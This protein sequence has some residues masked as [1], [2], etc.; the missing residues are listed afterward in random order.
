MLKANKFFALILCLVLAVSCHIFAAEDYVT[1]KG[2]FKDEY[3]DAV[4][5]FMGMG[6]WSEDMAAKSPDEFISRASFADMLFK[7]TAVSDADFSGSSYFWDVTEETVGYSAINRLAEAGIVSGND[8]GSFAP[9]DNLTLY[10]AA[11]LIVC[12]LGYSVKAEFDGGYSAGYL[13]VA[14]RLGI[15]KGLYGSGEEITKENAVIMLY[16]ALF[17]G[18]N[19]IAKINKNGEATFSS[20]KDETLLTKKFDIYK[21]EGKITDNGYTSLT[22]ESAV[23]PGKVKING[24]SLDIGDTNADELLGYNVTVYYREENGSGK[25]TIVHIL[26]EDK[27]ETLKIKADDIISFSDKVYKYSENDKK[28]KEA[29][30]SVN[31]DIIYN[32]KPIVYNPVYFKPQEGYVELINDSGGTNEYNTVII[33][34]IKNIVVHAVNLDEKLISGKYDVKPLNISDEGRDV[35][36]RDVN[37]N[38]V[39]PQDIFTWDVISYTESLDGN[40]IKATVVREYLSGRVTDISI[41]DSTKIGIEENEFELSKSYPN[42]GEYKI[43]TGYKGDFLLDITGKIAAFIKN[44]AG[45]LVFGYLAYVDKPTSGHNKN[46]EIKILSAERGILQVFET[47]E[48]VK[49]DG[50][51]VKQNS[52]EITGLSDGVIRYRLNSDG[53]I[54]EIDTVNLGN[55][56]NEDN[57]L[58][59]SAPMSS[60]ALYFKNGNVSGRAL[61]GGQTVVFIVPENR[62]DYEKYR[63]KNVSYFRTNYTYAV[64]A[65]NTSKEYAYA[66]AVLMYGSGGDGSA[67]TQNTY[68]AMVEKIVYT[69][70]EEGMPCYRLYYGIN[71]KKEDAIICDEVKINGS[72]RTM[73]ATELTPGSVIRIGTDY[74]SRINEVDLLYLSNADYDGGEFKGSSAAPTVGFNDT[75]RFLFGYVYLTKDG[76][77]KITAKHPSEM[78]EFNCDNTESRILAN[79]RCMMLDTSGKNPYVRNASADDFL[80]YI[81]YGDKCLK[82]IVQTKNADTYGIMLVR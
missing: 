54:C 48:N 56:E 19:D 46:T 33:T 74:K 52:S 42:E 60:S 21:L 3:F 77:I 39:D 8:N 27:N 20:Q 71:S 50:T 30:I 31:A 69:T 53:K 47:A 76:V 25:R 17:V 64:E 59:I 58:F 9:Y 49:L 6:V 66:D 35:I 57:S 11:K 41:G 2:E 61:I 62:Y 78:T 36:I 43:E 80:D 15:I 29:K 28:T 68:M 18:V 75:I 40:L 22:G 12:A 63:V 67:I 24:I 44:E 55:N 79:F 73:R 7:A 14:N 16:R 81:H 72:S 32:G 1:G 70:D 4:E 13:T 5:L 82:V 23:K 10:Q 38:P 45:G 51:R 65:Y 37:G 26:D 34:D